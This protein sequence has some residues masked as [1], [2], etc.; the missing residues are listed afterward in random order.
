MYRLHSNLDGC[1]LMH[2][3]GQAWAVALYRLGQRLQ[4]AA[5]LDDIID[6]LL[7]QTVASLEAGAAD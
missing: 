5:I 2:A 3:A 7:Y 1:M 6:R 4:E